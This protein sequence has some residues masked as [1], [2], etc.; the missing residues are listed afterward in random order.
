MRS[1]LLLLNHSVLFLC[2]S[3]YLGTGWSLW[4][5]SFPTSEALTV[6]NY[7]SH[8]VPQVA[9]ATAFLTPMTILMMVCV[10]IMI[11]S[12]WKTSLRWV[13]LAVLATIL[14]ATALTEWVIF[15]LNGEMSAHITDPARLK[16]VLHDWM[17]LNRVRIGLWTVQWVC[18]MI[19]FFRWAVRAREQ[20]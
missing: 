6:D 20:S 3:M 2:C 1:R 4:L 5:F 8:L 11:W 17:N 13:S 7:Y 16:V 9:A 15:P 14:A 18:M 19:W 12:E 10:A